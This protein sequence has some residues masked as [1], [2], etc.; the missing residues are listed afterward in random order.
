[1]LDLD[2]SALDYS[3]L[4]GGRFWW[5]PFILAAGM[6]SY[7]QKHGLAEYERREMPD[8]RDSWHFL[9]EGEIHFAEV[10]YESTEVE[11]VAVEMN[12]IDFG[13]WPMGQFSVMLGRDDKNK[14]LLWVWGPV[15]L[16]SPKPRQLPDHMWY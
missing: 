5:W 16:Y 10:I 3:L 4:G 12:W 2:R 7:L 1:M 11:T 14:R 13:L 6:Q 8:Y 15:T 9:V